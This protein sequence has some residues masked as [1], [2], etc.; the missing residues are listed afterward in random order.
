MEEEIK[1]YFNSFVIPMN[2]LH[3]F[4]SIEQS[5]G[6]EMGIVCFESVVVEELQTKN[7]NT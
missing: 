7:N 3:I 5:N 4:I 6:D 1:D 2:K